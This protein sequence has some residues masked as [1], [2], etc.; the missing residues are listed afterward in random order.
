[1]KTTTLIAL[2][3]ATVSCIGP[4]DFGDG[5]IDSGADGDTECVPELEICDGID[6]D[7]DEVLPA[8]EADADGDGWKICDGDCDDTNFFTNPAM[9]ESHAVG[10]CFDFQDNDCDGLADGDDPDCKS[11]CGCA[12]F[13]TTGTPRPAQIAVSSFIYLL[14]LGFILIRLRRFTL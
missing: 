14:P 3:I 12:V 1:M 6:N 2:A 13:G 5:G 9:W 7:C 4:V 11:D 10:N 8:D